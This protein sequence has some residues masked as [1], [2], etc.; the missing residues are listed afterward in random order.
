MK[1]QR[2][3]GGPKSNPNG[4]GARGER[5]RSPRTRP[6]TTERAGID[7]KGNALHAPSVRVLLGRDVTALSGHAAA[8]AG[9]RRDARSAVE[10][11]AAAVSRRT[12]ADALLLASERNASTAASSVARAALTGHA[13][14]AAS[15]R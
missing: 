5:P 15:L 1:A 11:V 12:A 9:V 13:A 4:W 6:V 2:R 3:H 8:A 10:Q 14:A 7:R